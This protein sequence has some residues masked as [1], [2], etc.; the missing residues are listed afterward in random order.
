MRSLSEPSVVTLVVES[1]GV[2]ILDSVDLPAT[3]LVILCH[4]LAL[5]SPATVLAVLVLTSALLLGAK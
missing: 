5:S 2:M 3:L 1:A 4:E